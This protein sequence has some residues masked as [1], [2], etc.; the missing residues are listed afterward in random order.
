VQ[1]SWNTQNTSG[2]TLSIDGGAPTPAA[3]QETRAAPFDC[4]AAS[5]RYTLATTGGTPV[6]TQSVTVQ[7]NNP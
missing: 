2:T 4:S 7:N 6:A 3:S 1:L 5:H